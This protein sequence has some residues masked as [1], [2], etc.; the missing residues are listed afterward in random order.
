MPN[1]SHIRTNRDAFSALSESRQPPLRSG[2][3]ATTPTVRP[4][5]RPRPTT[6]LGAQRRLQLLKAV[7]AVVED[8]A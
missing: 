5:S 6:M 2:L 7:G 4:A 8:R 3:L 1:A